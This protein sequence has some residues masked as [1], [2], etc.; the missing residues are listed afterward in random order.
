MRHLAFVLATVALLSQ[1]HAAAPKSTTASQA[2]VR[3]GK[4]LPAKHLQRLVALFPGAAI[5][6]ETVTVF[7]KDRNGAIPINVKT[8]ETINGVVMD[9]HNTVDLDKKGGMRINEYER[10]GEI[11]TKQM[12]HRFDEDPHFREAFHANT[13]RAT[14]YRFSIGEF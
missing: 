1:A 10:S 8:T 13:A 11:S 5:H 12:W 14:A 2:G 6:H 9:L 4:P 7:D 3:A